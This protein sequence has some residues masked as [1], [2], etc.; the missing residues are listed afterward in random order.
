MDVVQGT[1]RRRQCDT[2][3]DRQQT[4]F[5]VDQIRPTL[6][7]E[8]RAFRHHNRV[9]RARFDAHPAENAAQHVDLEPVGILLPI[10]PRRP[11]RLDR[12]ALGRTRCRAH[13]AR[14]AL[15]P[16]LIVLC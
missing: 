4:L 11:R 1:T 8:L 12:N 14:D 16:S 5:R 10:R 9:F 7:R 2:L 15:R 3:L 6:S 13:I